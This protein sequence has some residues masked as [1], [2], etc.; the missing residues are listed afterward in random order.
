MV[1]Q[2]SHGDAGAHHA[3]VV[4]PGAAYTEKDGIYDFEG[5]VQRA[6]RAAFPPGEAKEDWAILRALSEV[7]N[8]K[9]PY[10]DRAALVAP[11]SCGT[12]RISRK[13]AKFRCMPIP[14]PPP[15]ALS[16]A[17]GRWITGTAGP[18][19]HQNIA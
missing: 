9:L 12:R 11:P 7:L 18:C 5:R 4:L 16:A 3:D 19:H 2:G 17:Q 10:D 13:S 8:L 1:Y 6:K 14:P 15:G